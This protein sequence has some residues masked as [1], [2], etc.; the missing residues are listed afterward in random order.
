MSSRDCDG[1]D[2]SSSSSSSGSV[3]SSSSGK[4]HHDQSQDEQQSSRKRR[5][6]SS[7]SSSSSSGSSSSSSSSSSSTSTSSDSGSSSSENSTSPPLPPS[8]SHTSRGRHKGT[9]T[10][11][12][13]Q[14]G[15][16]SHRRVSLESKGQSNETEKLHRRSPGS[17][18]DAAFVQLGKVIND[19]TPDGSPKRQEHLL[20][21]DGQQSISEVFLKDVPSGKSEDPQ[22]MSVDQDVQSSLVDL[23][24][25]P[26]VQ[27]DENVTPVVEMVDLSEADANASASTV[28]MAHELNSVEKSQRPPV[29]TVGQQTSLQNEAS[30]DSDGSYESEGSAASSGVAVQKMKS[31]IVQVVHHPSNAH[32]SNSDFAQPR[33]H[34]RSPNRR[35]E[36]QQSRSPLESRERDG[37][38]ARDNFDRTAQERVR[39]WGRDRDEHHKH[40]PTTTTTTA[41][42]GEVSVVEEEPPAKKK[43]TEGEE[44]LMRSGG[45]YIPPAKLRMLQQQI[46]DKS[47]VV[48]QRMSW[49]ALKKSIIGIVNKVNVS[50]IKDITR[51]LFR[52]NLVRGRGLLARSIIQAQ[53]ASPTF[54]HVYASFASLINSKFPQNGELILKR[55]ILNFR[56]GYRRND[57]TLCLTTA[58]FIAHLVNHDMAHEVLAL[59]I[60]TL[61]LEQPTDDSVEVAVGFLK[62]CGLK[63]SDVSPRGLNA[64]Y[65]RLRNILHESA[66]DKRVQYMI[67][68]VFAVRKDGFKDHPIIFS[69]LNKVKQKEKITH[70]LTLEDDYNPEDLMNIFKEE[71]NFLQNEDRY[72]AIKERMSNFFYGFW[73]ELLN[74]LFVCFYSLVTDNTLFC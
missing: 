58:K 42:Q 37:R 12:D 64:I 52:E 41:K 11:K 25:Q 55:L 51:D 26:L 18:C 1:K 21:E 53:I 40:A 31:S 60:L 68:V 54:T 47:S 46:T 7:S 28:E 66:I 33:S 43:K 56:K 69:G 23:T 36:R 73:A 22:D 34:S 57:K 59:E 44:L 29:L 6:S 62:E 39:N 67:E 27:K 9:R 10:Q 38:S 24:K 13:D 65:E 71:D 17:T 5:S 61:L 49:E 32:C 4:P 72:L 48:Y 63:L 3:S 45:A 16:H 2:S 14:G 19:K 15:Q 70:M 20:L 30:E 50:N 8:T 74:F 35:R